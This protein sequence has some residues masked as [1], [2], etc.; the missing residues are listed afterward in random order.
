VLNAAF[1]TT[2]HWDGNP[3]TLEQQLK[4]PLS[5]FAEMNLR[6]YDDLTASIRARADY[7]AAFRAEMGVE[8]A[9]ITREHVSRALASFQRTLVSGNSPFDRYYYGKNKSALSDDA[10]HGLELFQ[11]K[12]SCSA[13][14]MIEENYALFTDGRFHRLGIGYVPEKQV[15]S[16][17]GVGMVSNKDYAGM[18]FTP[19]LRNV[20]E[21]APYMHDGS[22]PT[23]EDAIQLHYQRPDP[24]I[25]RD[26][27][28]KPVV[29]SQTE[30]GYLAAFL[31]S[32]T[33]EERYNARGERLN[34][35]AGQPALGLLR[36]SSK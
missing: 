34:Q 24:E 16:D 20:A 5:G 12:A 6:S 29:L 4:Y 2:L 27:A 35:G 15:Y 11:G 32:L 17:P 18:F 3:T 23:I 1:K 22:A 7:V 25:N 14:H 31:R 9:D 8:P 21:T 33:G 26:T 28:L 36:R 10:K 30:L 19:S 13:C